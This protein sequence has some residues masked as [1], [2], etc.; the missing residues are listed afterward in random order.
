MVLRIEFGYTY[1]QVAEALARPTPNAARL[2]VTRA[3][4]RLAGLMHEFGR[5]A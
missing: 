3:L 2:L 4:L 5:E 1:P